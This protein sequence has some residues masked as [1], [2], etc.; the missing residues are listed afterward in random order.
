MFCPVCQGQYLSGLQQCPE[1]LVPL[2]EEARGPDDPRAV[3]KELTLL[4]EAPNFIEADLIESI[5]RAYEIPYLVKRENPYAV[6]ARYSLGPL[7]VHRI[8][9]RR[10]HLELAREIL[11]A[12]PELWDMPDE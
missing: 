7:A 4:V 3:T 2:L 1:C 8:L 5:L 12:E 11:A 9:V 10:D 6:D